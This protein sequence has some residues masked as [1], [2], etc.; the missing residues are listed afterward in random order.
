MTGEKINLQEK[1][2]GNNYMTV[3]KA[4]GNSQSVRRIRPTF[5]H[6]EDGQKETM[7]QGM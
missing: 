2:I 5:A 7:S 3:D 4:A 6:F 1:Q